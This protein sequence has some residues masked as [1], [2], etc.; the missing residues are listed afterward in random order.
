MGYQIYRATVTPIKGVLFDMDGVILD[1]EKLYARFWL[2]AM[3]IH[4]GIHQLYPLFL[5][6][7][8]GNPRP[9]ITLQLGLTGL[10]I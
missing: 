6:D 10:A 4:I 9:K 8:T 3:D 5:N 7:S 1:T 2:Y